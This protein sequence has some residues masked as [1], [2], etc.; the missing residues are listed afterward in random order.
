MTEEKKEYLILGRDDC[1]Y[2][3]KAKTL[4]DDISKKYTFAKEV[5]SQD[6][7]VLKEIAGSDFPT[8]PQIFKYKKGGGLEYIGGF[9]EL[10]KLFN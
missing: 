7:A 3:I 1:S 10:S 6:L 9:T 8:V 5:N 2:C 4:L